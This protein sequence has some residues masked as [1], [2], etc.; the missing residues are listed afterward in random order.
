MEETA[1]AAKGNGPFGT[2][3]STVFTAVVAPVAVSLII[4]HVN[5]GEARTIRKE[6]AR[7][8]TPPPATAKGSSP[9]A[10]ERT[11]LVAQGI[12][13][14]PEEALQDALRNALRTTVT[15]VV[16]PTIWA[17]HGDHLFAA[18]LRDNAGLIIGHK[19]LSI[20]AQ[21]QQGKHYYSRT[22]SVVIARQL[23]AER[24]TTAAA[25]LKE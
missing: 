2:L 22:V 17:R 14:T 19:D 9:S 25:N 11:H 24:V 5:L 6:E 23:L 7:T 15:N 3:L 13:W 10:D 20:T 18:I 12:G 21:S 4:Q 16:D 8:P 1:M